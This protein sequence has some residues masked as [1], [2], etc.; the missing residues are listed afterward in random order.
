MEENARLDAGLIDGG[1][2]DDMRPEDHAADQLESA[3]T[4][5]I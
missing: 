2:E 3:P 4:S 5:L 1:G